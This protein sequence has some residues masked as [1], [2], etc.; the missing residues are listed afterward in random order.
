MV[1]RALITGITGQDGSY[2]AELLLA[3]GYDVHG[4]VR[5]SS[6]EKFERIALI[7]DRVT[8]HQ[9][10]LLDQYSL[11]SLLAMIEPSDRE[12]VLELIGAGRAAAKSQ[13]AP[14]E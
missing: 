12:R 2:L 5:R 6:E 11:A 10:D 13:G 8:L 7:R 14:S 3:K 9:G 1:K 4:M